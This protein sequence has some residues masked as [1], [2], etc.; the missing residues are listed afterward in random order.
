MEH[1]T[2]KTRYSRTSKKGFL[3]QITQIERRQARIRRIRTRLD[4]D[5]SAKPVFEAETGT[6]SND[7]YHIGKTQNHPENIISFVQK[8]TGDPAVKVSLLLLLS[9]PFSSSVPLI[10]LAFHPSTERTPSST[11]PK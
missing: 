8:H 9:Y 1:R 3:K 5:R 2:P 4:L 6:S 10:S 7:R 11:D